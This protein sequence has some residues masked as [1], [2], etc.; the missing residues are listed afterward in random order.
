MGPGAAVASRVTIGRGT[1][2]GAGAVIAP[3]VT[4][5]SNSFI[6]V[7]SVVHKDIPS[8]VF[9]GG[10]PARIIERDIIGPRGHAV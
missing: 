10:N 7:G 9:V 3:G 6:A 5:G 2:V 8:N 4:I 1:M